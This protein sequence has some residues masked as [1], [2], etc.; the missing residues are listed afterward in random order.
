MEQITLK[1]SMN[2]TIPMTAIASSSIA[3][4]HAV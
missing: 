1:E 4:G 3:Y 2:R